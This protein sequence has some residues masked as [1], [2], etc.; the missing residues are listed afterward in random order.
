MAVDA[1]RLWRF[2]HA[3]IAVA[4]SWFGL[5]PEITPT[6]WRGDRAGVD[7]QAAFEMG[8]ADLSRATALLKNR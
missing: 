2:D 1:D 8:A 5:D 6:V 7:H 4:A 3:G